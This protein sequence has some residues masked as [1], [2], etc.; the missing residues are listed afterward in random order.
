MIKIKENTRKCF[1]KKDCTHSCFLNHGY[2][3]FSFWKKNKKK[4]CK[5]K[6]MRKKEKKQLRTSKNKENTKKMFRGRRSLI[7]L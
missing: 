1:E 6:N 7:F 3:S 4:E 2:Q 5:Q